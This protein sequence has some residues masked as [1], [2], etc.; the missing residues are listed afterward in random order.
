[1]KKVLSLN[2]IHNLK[3][4]PKL[5]LS[6]SLVLV[7][8]IVVSVYSISVQRDLA[9]SNQDMFENRMQF[10]QH[11]L[12]LSVEFQNLNSTVS[13]V[14]LQDAVLAKE[15]VPELLEKYNKVSAKVEELNN[16]LKNQENQIIAIIWQ[17]YAKDFEK[18]T[19]FL[20]QSNTMVGQATGMDL[21]ITT[22]NKQMK[23]KT[24][25]LSAELSKWTTANSEIAHTS[26]QQAYDKSKQS[27]IMMYIFTALAVLLSAVVGKL[28]ADSIV[29]PLRLMLNA[30]KLM[31][32]GQLNQTVHIQRKDELGDLS[33]AFN[34]LSKQMQDIIANVRDT[35]LRVGRSM[36]ELSVG[37]DQTAV[38]TTTITE[39][40]QDIAEHSSK[41]F[42]L[43]S[44]NG[45][46]ISKLTDDIRNIAGISSNVLLV[47]QDANQLATQGQSSIEIAV[48]QMRII[49]ET[50]DESVKMVETLNTSMEQINKMAMVISTISGQTN[51]LSL[52]AS[53]EAARAGV[54][55]KGFAVV[56]SEIKKLSDISGKASKD[57]SNLIQEIDR[58]TKKVL[59]ITQRG[60]E[61]VVKGVERVST[62]GSS[63]QSIV[64][65]MQQVT[66][67]N[68]HLHQLSQTMAESTSS[69][70]ESMNEIIALAQES[71][72]RTRHAATASEEQLATTEEFVALV[73]SVNQ[74]TKELMDS[75]AIFEISNSSAS[76]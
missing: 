69:M 16:A 61:E 7:L 20:Q 27:L 68:Q 75:L 23:S 31:A 57:I 22:Y 42:T 19:E 6:F 32:V 28:V 54:Q 76:R 12:L 2:W 35:A 26:Y 4:L 70:I 44:V 40:V 63:F 48:D 73:H 55:G 45:E 49:R 13:S 46:G 72:D 39:S 71:A 8:F 74:Q 67:E 24:D 5:Y 60:N 10:N 36:E 64:N 58:D 59:D 18:V 52:N 65:Q 41:Q 37:S 1:M 25:A 34:N 30:A 51:L 38:T 50:M 43:A 66:A 15:A 33:A 56:A 47:S 21:A 53:I 29:K 11:I 14:L 3:V 17:Q 62:A 9:A